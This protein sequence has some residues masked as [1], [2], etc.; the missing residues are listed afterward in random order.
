VLVAVVGHSALGIS[1]VLFYLAAYAIM[2]FGAFAVA[3]L[4]EDTEITSFHGL[5]T[6]QPLT[7]AFMAIYLAS[8]IGLPLTAG[9]FGKFYIFK[10]AIDAELYWL[11]GLGL[12]TS[13]VAAFYYLRIIIAMYVKPAP[14]GAPALPAPAPSLQVALVLS[15]AL[16]LGIG[17]FPGWLLDWA[18]RS[19]SLLR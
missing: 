15:A 16:T 4:Q 5:S 17:I 10:S 1:A 6:R 8:L 9:F 3:S 13:A 7:A 2:N 14:E 12:L 18:T 11:A 19:S